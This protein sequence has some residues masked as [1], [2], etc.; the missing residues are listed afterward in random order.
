MKDR[1]Q[2]LQVANEV[3]L[4]CI[5]HDLNEDFGTKIL[6][7]MLDQYVEKGTSY[8]NKEIRLVGRYDRPRYYLVNLHNDSAKRDTVL[9]KTRE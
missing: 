5:N 2:R 1:S 6:F 4:N 9:I 8:N 7:G 3:K